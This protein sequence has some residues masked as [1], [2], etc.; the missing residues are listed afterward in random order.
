MRDSNSAL[1][2]DD[3]DTLSSA[4]QM[5]CNLVG[6]PELARL[7]AVFSELPD[8]AQ[9]RCRR[10]VRQVYIE[11]KKQLAVQRDSNM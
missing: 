11:A 3:L 8:R 1:N 9:M 10:R 6:F 7:L 4:L 5:R 2:V